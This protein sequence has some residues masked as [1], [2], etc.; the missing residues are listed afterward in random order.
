MP[1][2]DDDLSARL[3]ALSPGLTRLARHLT[4]DRAQA[5]DLCQEVLLTLW[6]RPDRIRAVDNL[7]AY[8]RTALRN[9]YRQGLRRGA[10]LP[11]PDEAALDPV[12]P[13]A[14]AS[15]ALSEVR[16]AIARLPP[17]Q[18]RLI[19][20]V[21]EGETSPD[22]LAR[23]TGLPRGTVMSR[24]ARARATLRRDLGLAARAPIRAL[25]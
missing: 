22:A 12:W 19:R 5:E 13:R 25:F 1:P 8:A 21:M 4:R 9:L 23:L 17:P 3:I 2:P 20:L 7:P 6:A 11:L 14:F 16:A 24:L 10:L 18:A 15:I